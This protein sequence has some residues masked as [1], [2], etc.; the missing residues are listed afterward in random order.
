MK[1]RL[2]LVI[3]WIGFV[4]LVAFISLLLIGIANVGLDDVLGEVAFW[5]FCVAVAHYCTSPG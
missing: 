2:G 1:E 4:A 5:S 3:H